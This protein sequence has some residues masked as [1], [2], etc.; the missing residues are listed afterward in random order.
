[1]ILLGGR[2]IHPALVA[3]LL[4][5]LERR[6]HVVD[7]ELHL[8][9]HSYPSLP[10]TMLPD[11]RGGALVR[12]GNLSEPRIQI[13]GDD[14]GRGRGAEDLHVGGQGWWGVRAG[15]GEDGAEGRGAGAWCRLCGWRVWARMAESEQGREWWGL[16]RRQSLAPF[17]RWRSRRGRGWRGGRGGIRG[18]LSFHPRRAGLQG[19]ESQGRGHDTQLWT[20]SLEPYRVVVDFLYLIYV[21]YYF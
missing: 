4:E 5:G 7:V 8:L 20:P 3:L 16:P 11:R 14:R 1:M 6:E 18:I 9:L 12:Q 21:N 2:P 19:R 15:A 17:H 10:P 13:C